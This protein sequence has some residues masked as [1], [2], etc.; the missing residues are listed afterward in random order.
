[1]ADFSAVAYFFGRELQKARKVP[2]GL[3]HTS[4]GGTPAQAWTPRQV[5][6]A[7]PELK[8]YVELYDR[9]VKD[10]AVLQKNHEAALAKYQRSPIQPRNKAA[11]G[12]AGSK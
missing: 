3:I 8:R 2:I 4:Y 6:Q 1:M 10:Y 5:L 12:Y 7:N 11:P 9:A